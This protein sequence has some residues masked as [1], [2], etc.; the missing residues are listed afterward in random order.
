MAARHLACAVLVLMTGVSAAAAQE[1]PRRQEHF[2]TAPKWVRTP[3]D[4]ELSALFP[5]SAKAAHLNGEA[6]TVCRIMAEGRLADC[7]V[8]EENPRGYGFA[9]ASLQSLSLMQIAPP[10]EGR[11]LDDERLGLRF[12]WGA[13]GTTVQVVA[14]ARPAEPPA[15]SAASPSP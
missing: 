8:A 11:P 5:E 12:R 9:R 6:I 3:T 1:P 15:Q 10:D 13:A 14:P 7:I 4:A 2:L